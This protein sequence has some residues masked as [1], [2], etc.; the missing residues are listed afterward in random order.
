M[1]TFFVYIL[2]SAICMAAFY[3]FYKMLLSRET[4]HRFN[5]FALLGILVG[6]FVLPL[7]NVQSPVQQETTNVLLDFG[8]M[9]VEPFEMIESNVEED[10]FHWAS[11]LLL[12]Y[13]MGVVCFWAKHLFA[14]ASLFRLIRTGR[15]VRQE[16]GNVLVLYT[17]DIA[18]F[19]WMHYIVISE[20]DLAKNGEIIIRHETA[21]IRNCHSWD[22]I[23]ADLCISL[24]WFNPAVWLMKNELQ[25]VHEFEADEW[26]ISQGIDAKRY[27]L[28]LIEKAVGTR[29]YSMANS[30]NHSTLKKR[31]TMMIKK[32]SNPWARLKYLYVLPL[33][34]IA[35]AAFAR[36]EIS[37]ELDEISSAKVSDL[38]AIMKAE[39]PK[40]V[41]A[42]QENAIMKGLIIDAETDLPIAGASVLI[43]GTAKGTLSD[44]DGRFR[45]P[46]EVGQVLEFYYVGK[47]NYSFA[48]D[49]VPAKEVTV[50]MKNAKDTKGE[51]VIHPTIEATATSQPNQQDKKGQQV[52]KKNFA[53]D[54]VF[55]VVENMPEYPGGM[56]ELMTFLGKN[57]KYPAEATKANIQGRVIVE[58]VVMKDGSVANL[59]IKRSVHPL[60]D[61]EAL[62][63]LSTMPK[64]KPG[65]QRGKA[66]NVKFVVPVTFR[67]N[68]SEKKSQDDG[69]LTLRI[70]SNEKNDALDR[71]QQTVNTS[72]TA[73]NTLKS[74]IIIV[75]KKVMGAGFDT[76]KDIDSS[77]IESI[78]V[79]KSH[80]QI[81]KFVSQGI[82]LQLSETE[83][84]K[85][86]KLYDDEKNN[87]VLFITTKK[88]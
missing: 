38:S 7:V 20:N 14:M 17:K 46:V 21:H 8:N 28:L 56:K 29:L 44:S 24:Q 41:V 59:A 18:P 5:R 30:F 82:P 47:Q 67:L 79:L 54:D 1:G 23:V 15:K 32:K 66:V 43:K 50:R 48:V 63:V 62:R 80:E 36:P 12:V 58:F 75:D 76:T 77:D 37:S 52:V 61:A 86:K 55:M 40:K 35:V 70:L 42:V 27:Q 4:F 83:I 25:H 74:P 51:L 22:L 72:N 45:M 64:W 60:L 88:K 71:A 84:Q 78:V 31:I 81:T 10:S 16:D 11:I 33:A 19:S 49:R 68:S 69:Q 26:V 87:G 6:S 13:L 34:T 9:M 57:V 73:S 65:T 2:K 39:S 53:D 85:F 3:L